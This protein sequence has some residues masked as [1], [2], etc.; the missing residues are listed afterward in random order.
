MPR[1]VRRYSPEFKE[2]AVRA[3]LVRGDRCVEDVA[4]DVGVHSSRL[5]E[6]QRALEERG[7]NPAMSSN[8]R[9]DEGPRGWSAERK[10]ETVMRSLGIPA[11]QL[12][13]VLRREGVHE[14]MLDEWKRDML[15]GLARRRNDS[16]GDSKRIALL[17]RE[18]ARKDKAL[19]ETAALLVLQKKVR[20]IWGDE[21]GGTPP[22]TAS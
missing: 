7:R 4:A 10:L 12:G 16:Q 9:R 17:E 18:L 13:E 15:E 20:E 5:Y 11:D 8:D 22:P 14:A 2:Q 3:L 6:W 21:G 19:A 1:Q